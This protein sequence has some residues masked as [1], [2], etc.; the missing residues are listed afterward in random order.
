[1]L[2]TNYFYHVPYE[3]QKMKNLV[4]VGTIS[5]HTV[6]RTEELNTEALEGA[7]D[8]ESARG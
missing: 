3:N 7:R 6:Q 8:K 1:M 5:S 2:Y 4:E